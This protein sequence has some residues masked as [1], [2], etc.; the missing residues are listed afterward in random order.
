MNLLKLYYVR[1]SKPS[2]TEA[3]P[4]MAQVHAACVVDSVLGECPPSLLGG[5]D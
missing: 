5:E 1:T 3:Q 2:S 4:N